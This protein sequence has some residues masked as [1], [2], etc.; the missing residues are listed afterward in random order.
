M[1]STEFEDMVWMLGPLHI[2][3]IFIKVIGDWL[4]NGD[5]TE[6][7]DYAN[8]PL[9]EIHLVKVRGLI[10]QVVSPIRKSK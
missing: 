7:H 6:V 10:H 5:W 1:R 3:Q 8:I 9:D 2:K 4:E